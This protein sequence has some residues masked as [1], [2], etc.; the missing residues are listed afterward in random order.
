MTDFSN[1]LSNDESSI[2]STDPSDL[3]EIVYHLEELASLYQKESWE[4]HQTVSHLDRRLRVALED[5]QR[6]ESLLTAEIQKRASQTS[7]LQSQLTLALE[8]LERIRSSTS[9]QVSARHSV[10]GD[11]EKAR[12]SP[13]PHR[14]STKEKT[15]SVINS[16]VAALTRRRAPL[17]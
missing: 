11:A 9:L 5:N 6:V 12:W 2:M 7:H 4:A 14:R 13:V 1:T 10:D 17:C 8:E 15:Q 16:I 3:E